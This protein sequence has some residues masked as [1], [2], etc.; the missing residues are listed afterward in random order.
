MTVYSGPGSVEYRGRTLRQAKNIKL[1]IETGNK[2]VMTL[3]DGRAGHTPGPEMCTV[4]V[5]SAIPSEQSGGLE[6]D[7]V[8][9][10]R[11]KQEVEFTYQIAGL[12]YRV[13]GDVRGVGLSTDAEGGANE[14][15]YQHVGI[16]VGAT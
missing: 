11:A 10:A 13:K 15:S 1:Q 8:A 2:D 5:A 7:F 9:L 14:V 4:D 16:I 6:I 3:A 12:R